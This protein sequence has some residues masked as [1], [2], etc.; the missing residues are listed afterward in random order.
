MY[1]ILAVVCVDFLLFICRIHYRAVTLDP[2]LSDS[3]SMK[4]EYPPIQLPWQEVI[5]RFLSEMNPGYS[6]QCNG[7]NT[8]Y[9]Y[10]FTLELLY[11]V[12]LISHHEQAD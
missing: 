4:G 6:I 10:V 7:V 12:Y 2:L 11:C 5:A 8:V 1:R 3:V 9:R